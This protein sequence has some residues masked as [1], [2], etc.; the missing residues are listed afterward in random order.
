MWLYKILI[1]VVSC[2]IR[3]Y[4]QTNGQLTSPGST[5]AADGRN[6]CC[7]FCLFLKEKNPRGLNK[8]QILPCCLNKQNW[9]RSKRA[10]KTGDAVCALNSSV[11]NS[12]WGLL[13]EFCPNLKDTD[14]QY[15]AKLI[16]DVYREPPRKDCKIWVRRDK[17]ICPS[18]VMSVKS[19]ITAVICSLTRA[20]AALNRPPPQK[21]T[22]WLFFNNK[23]VQIEKRFDVIIVKICS[24]SCCYFL[25]NIL[26]VTKLF[27]LHVFRIKNL[28]F[29]SNKAVR[30]KAPKQLD[31][32]S[33]EAAIWTLHRERFISRTRVLNRVLLFF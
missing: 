26:F 29:D 30:I 3:A 5:S 18:C 1:R 21:K 17:V 31:S 20:G 32:P 7:N 24:R 16:R 11:G 14:A 12:L 9:G 2:L 28:L 33:M 27:C 4:G 19:I 6:Y 15:S 23:N 25:R 8:A 22:S 10:K 13:L